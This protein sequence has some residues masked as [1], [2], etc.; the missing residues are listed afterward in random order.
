MNLV[1]CRV[2]KSGIHKGELLHTHLESGVTYHRIC[3]GADMVY[4]WNVAEFDAR[5]LPITRQATRA[6]YEPVL[7]K[8]TGAT[9]VRLKRISRLP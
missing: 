9:G 1:I 4:A 3:T 7:A 8:L 5:V 2:F 6:E